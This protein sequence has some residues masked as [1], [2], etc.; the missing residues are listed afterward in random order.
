MSKNPK[1]VCEKG[2]CQVYARK[3]GERSQ[4]ISV[5]CCGNASGSVIV[6]PFVI[7]KGESLPDNLNAERYPDGTTFGKSKSGYMVTELFFE[8]MKF[9][10]SK[11]PPKRPVLLLLDGT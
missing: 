9:F 5:A 1:I 2:S 11:I 6:P 3:S 7:F 8:W 4:L 10:I